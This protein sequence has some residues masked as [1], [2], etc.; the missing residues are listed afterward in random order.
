MKKYLAWILAALCALMPVAGLA[1]ENRDTQLT[2]TLPREH[3]ITVVCGAGG[4]VRVEGTVYTGT[5]TFIVDRLSAFTLEAVPDAG[6]R[7]SQVMAQPSGGVSITGNTVS[8]GSVYEDKTLTLSFAR[9]QDEPQPPKPTPTPTPTAS[10]TP[11]PGPTPTVK[12]TPTP[13]DGGDG[14]DGED[15][16]G[17]GEDGDGEDGASASRFD[18]PY[19]EG[20]GNVL[21]DDYLGTGDGLSELGIVYD[22]TYGQD[23]YEL[24]AV[25]YE[26]DQ[27]EENTLL[28]VAQPD[29]DGTYAQRSMVLTGLQL[30]RLWQEKDIQWIE[31][32]NGEAGAL[33][34]VEELITGETAKFIDWA[35][36]DPEAARPEEAWELPEAEL[37]AGQL[38]DI[39]IEVRI[40]P[41]EQDGYRFGVYAWYAGARQ[42]IGELTPSFQVCVSAGEQGGEEERAAYAAAHALSA[43]DETGAV[44]YLHSALIETPAREAEDRTDPAEYF[45]VSMEDGPNPVVLYDPAMP[46]DRYRRWSLCAYWTGDAAYRLLQLGD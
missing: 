3:T 23:E 19:V 38:G 30:A 43:E 37:T 31:L 11:T 7:L 40:A 4:A 10:P 22:E 28:A 45:S 33:I 21:Y 17:D 39:R 15:E 2:T 16:D 5:R 8:I 29:E 46:L 42:A 14:E 44:E 26:E 9:E 41:D 6:Y 24:L 12:P 1:A 34:R 36:A 20:L 35:L 27:A 13:G 18:L 32:R 25:L